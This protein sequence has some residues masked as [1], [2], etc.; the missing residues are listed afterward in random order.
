M[1][2][3]KATVITTFIRTNAYVNEAPSANRQNLQNITQESGE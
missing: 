1:E 2:I 3:L